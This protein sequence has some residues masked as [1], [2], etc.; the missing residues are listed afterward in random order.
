VIDPDGTVLVTGG[1]GLLGAAVARHLVA[2]HGVRRLVLLSRRAR[3]RGAAELVASWRRLGAR[4]G[5][6]RVRRGDRAA[7]AAVLADIPAAHPLTAVVHAAGAL[8]DALIAD[9]T[10]SGWRR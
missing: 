8:D 3:G 1:P 5:W 6:S 9:L 7:L 2:R 4:C 10:R